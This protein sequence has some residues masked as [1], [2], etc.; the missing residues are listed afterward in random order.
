M[1]L[2]QDRGASFNGTTWLDRTNYYETMPASDANLE[3]GISFEAD[4]MMNAMIRSQSR[5]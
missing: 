3:F 1:K 4:R 2:L 5:S